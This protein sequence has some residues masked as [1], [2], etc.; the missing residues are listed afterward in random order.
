LFDETGHV[1]LGDAPGFGVEIDE[2]I[3]RRYLAPG[4]ALF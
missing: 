4:E 3:A 2:A 1:P